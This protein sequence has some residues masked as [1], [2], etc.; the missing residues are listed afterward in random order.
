L[1]AR[2]EKLQEA[3]KFAREEANSIEVE[4]QKVGATFF[5]YLFGA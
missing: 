1:L 5:D 2:V 4:D 3:V